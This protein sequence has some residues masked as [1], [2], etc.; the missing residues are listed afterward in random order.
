MFSNQIK[1]PHEYNSISQKPKI[2]WGIRWSNLPNKFVP[3]ALLHLALFVV[4][5]NSKKIFFF[6]SNTDKLNIMKETEKLTQK[7]INQLLGI[8]EK[9]FFT[10]KFIIKTT[11]ILIMI[12]VL[13]LLF[14]SLF[15]S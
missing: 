4:F 6:K 7:E 2:Y 5:F 1:T 14:L 9:S 3:S 8:N 10:P 11:I 12:N 15:H 13:L